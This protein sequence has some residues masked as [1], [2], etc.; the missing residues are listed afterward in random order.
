MKKYKIPDYEWVV[1]ELT[2]FKVY[3]LYAVF[4]TLDNYIVILL[5]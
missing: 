4:R 5:K 3:N 1:F 2:H